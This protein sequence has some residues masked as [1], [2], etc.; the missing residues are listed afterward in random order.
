MSVILPEFGLF[1]AAVPKIACTS[2]K[3]FFYRAVHGHGFRPGA[4]K[5]HI[6]EVYQ[7]FARDN[8]PPDLD[9]DRF[10]NRVAIVRQPVHRFISAYRNRVGALRELS[11]EKAG[12]RL[13]ELGLEPDPPLDRF[14]DQF[15]L[16]RQAH[17]SIFHHTRPMVDFL[18]DDPGFFHRIYAIDDVDR[19]AADMN[20]LMGTEVKMTRMQTG[21]PRVTTA[22]LSKPQRQKIRR[23]YKQD[24]RVFREFWRG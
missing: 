24:F 23:F 5:R 10:D 17:P 3:S 21:G 8:Y 11:V 4:G 14:V 13:A 6:H 15:E 7:T 22:D 2:V 18:G 9:W 12:P 1:Y 20:A 19:F 16:Y